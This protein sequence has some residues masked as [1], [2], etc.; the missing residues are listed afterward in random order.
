VSDRE[1]ESACGGK[2]GGFDDRSSFCHVGK[3][4]EEANI[5]CIGRR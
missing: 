1:R 3:F 2:V 5:S 4:F